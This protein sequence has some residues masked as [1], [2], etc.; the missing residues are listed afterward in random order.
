MTGNLETLIKSHRFFSGMK[1]EHVKDMA[2][3]ASLKT[4]T[5]GTML[6]R[7]NTPANEF[8]AILSG[9][10]AIETYVPGGKPKVL[11][12]MHGGEI[13]GWSWLFSPHE[14][15]FDARAQTDLTVI[16]FDGW[17][18]RETCH[19]HPELGFELMKRIAQVMTSRLKAARIQLLD[20]YGR[21]NRESTSENKP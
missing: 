10:V 21:D 16:A 17:R 6:A 13:V 11:Q 4:V 15:V 18:L 7:E 5:K 19:G 2:T 9:D 12:T 8:F 14:W 1:P 3:C 20:I